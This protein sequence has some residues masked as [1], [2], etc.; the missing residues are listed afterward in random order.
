MQSSGFVEAIYS[1]NE[2]KSE[3]KK[4]LTKLLNYLRKEI[5]ILQ[6]QRANGQTGAKNNRC[7][8]ISDVIQIAFSVTKAISHSGTLRI[9]EQIK[10]EILRF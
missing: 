9:S 3:V 8:F 7:H 2:C 5:M 4:I 6:L 10:Q 1:G